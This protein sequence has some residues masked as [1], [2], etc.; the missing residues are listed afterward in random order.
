[1]KDEKIKELKAQ[2]YDLAVKQA[3][4]NE[5]YQVQSQQMKQASDKL[6]KELNEVEAKK[7]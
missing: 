7:K 6:V 2:L 5:N 3:K 4:L 1:M